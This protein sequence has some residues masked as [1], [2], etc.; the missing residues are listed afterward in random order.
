MFIS[1][2]DVGSGPNHPKR[3]YQIMIKMKLWIINPETYHS[4][5]QSDFSPG[6]TRGGQCT[7]KL[8]V[9]IYIYVYI[10][11]CITPHYVQ[12]CALH[13]VHNFVQYTYIY[14]HR[15]MTVVGLWMCTILYYFDIHTSRIKHKAAK[16]S[17]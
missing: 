8:C 14:I 17:Y 15:S 12:I 9:C 6:K 3:I 2:Y 4:D 13:I 10:Y 7:A 11:I 5:L 16:T 1:L